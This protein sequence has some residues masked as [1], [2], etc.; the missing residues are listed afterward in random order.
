MLFCWAMASGLQEEKDKNKTRASKKA[1]KFQWRALDKKCMHFS[2]FELEPLIK[3]RI[4]GILS[5]SGRLPVRKKHGIILAKFVR[6]L[7]KNPV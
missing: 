4:P 6:A 7:V 1:F 2:Y 5:A 3:F